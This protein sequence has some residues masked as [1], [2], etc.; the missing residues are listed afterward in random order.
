MLR[1]AF[2][3]A[4]KISAKCRKW[5]TIFLIN[6]ECFSTMSIMLTMSKAEVFIKAQLKPATNIR[7]VQ[8]ISS[9]TDDLPLFMNTVLVSQ[10][11]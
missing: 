5:S 3:A 6:I 10:V 11:R 7:Q 1:L 2:H 9:L 4:S 8:N